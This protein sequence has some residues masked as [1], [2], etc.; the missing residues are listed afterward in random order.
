MLRLVG[1]EKV[2]VL[3]E[4]GAQPAGVGEDGVEVAA[5][6]RGDVF[7]GELAAVS[8]TPACGKRAATE[9]RAGTTTSSR[10]R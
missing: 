1:G 8:R 9:L 10:W 3:L 7:A 5:A 2:I 6:K 4:G